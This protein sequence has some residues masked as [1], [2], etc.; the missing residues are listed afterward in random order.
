MEDCGLDTIRAVLSRI[1]ASQLVDGH[2]DY[3]I[4]PSASDESEIRN[5]AIAHPI[6][7]S[8]VLW[9]C[10]G[11]YALHQLCRS[12]ASLHTIQAVFEVFPAA[13]STK[14]RYGELPIHIACEYNAPLEVVQFLVQKNPGSL[15]EID[16]SKYTPL[17][18]ACYCGLRPLRVDVIAF[19]LASSSEASLQKSCSGTTPLHTLLYNYGDFDCEIPIEAVRVLLEAAPT[20]I[21]MYD[22]RGFQ[23]VHHAICYKGKRRSQIPFL[24]L[25]L[26]LK[27]TNPRLTL[28]Q[29]WKL[30]EPTNWTVRMQSLSCL[31]TVQHD[32][33]GFPKHPIHSI[34]QSDN[35]F[36]E[37]HFME[38]I[39]YFRCKLGETDDVG[40]LPLHLALSSGAGVPAVAVLKIMKLEPRALSVR[41]PLTGLFPFM[42]ACDPAHQR[43]R[44]SE[45]QLLGIIY[46]AINANP[47]NLLANLHIAGNTF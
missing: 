14:N 9:D 43:D 2:Y 13:V 7:F 1:S 5:L 44:F 18:V 16:Q 35:L 15:L 36:S 37:E 45:G 38:S 4:S 31:G 28:A 12:G 33:N 25:K 6:A 40:R 20:A 22:R 30:A 42:M 46:Q 32:D 19:L 11:E 23:P 27:S 29:I 21:S 3:T 8:T 39:L 17:H 10:T 41:D 24:A 47:A 34:L 26:L